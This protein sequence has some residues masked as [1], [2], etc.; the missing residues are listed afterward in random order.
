MS[1]RIPAGAIGKRGI[2]VEPITM[3]T[4]RENAGVNPDRLAELYVELGQAGAESAVCRAMEELS[5]RLH[6]IHAACEPL[7]LNTVE[8]TARSMMGIAEQIG[9]HKLAQVA[10]DVQTAAAQGDPVSLA[11]TVSRLLRIGESSLT[12]IWDLQELAL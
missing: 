11:A 10:G 12:G 9:M 8:K 6:R 1:V 2:L 4:H 7:N 5:E 3:L